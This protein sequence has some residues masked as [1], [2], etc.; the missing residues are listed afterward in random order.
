[1]CRDFS[2]SPYTSA[3]PWLRRLVAGHSPRRSGFAPG[4]VRMG[5]VVQKVALG[6]AFL[7]VLWFSTASVIPPWLFILTYHLGDEQLARCWP[8]FRDVVSPHRHE[9]QQQ[10]VYILVRRPLFDPQWDWNLSVCHHALVLFSGY[11]DVFP[12]VK[13]PVCEAY[14]LPHPVLML[15]MHGALCPLSHTCS[16]HDA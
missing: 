13:W 2:G 4:S 6:Q 14:N 3:V 5:F 10:L 16:W 12:E 1:M 11:G 8:Q 9:Q 7:Q 15:R